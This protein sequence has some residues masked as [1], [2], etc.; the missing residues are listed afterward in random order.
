MTKGCTAFW[1]DKKGEKKIC[2]VGSVG[3]TRNPSL[4]RTAA[5]ARAR[6]EIARS[7]EVKVQAMLKDYQATTTGGQEFGTGAADEQHVVDVSKQITNTTL[8]GTELADSWVSANGTFYALVV[9]DA[10]K[11]KDSVSQMKNLSESIR[12]AVIE[13]ADKAFEE[14]DTEIQKQ[15]AK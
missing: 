13:R 15:E 12:K 6:T 3:G 4:A 8:S 5:M 7:L 1:G 9:W 10:D 2:G 11:F 14:L